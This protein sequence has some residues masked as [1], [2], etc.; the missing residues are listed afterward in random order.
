MILAMFQ[1]LC[2]WEFETIWVNFE[3]PCF[4]TCKHVT[5]EIG[6]SEKCNGLLL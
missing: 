3:K 6:G 4:Y 1:V 2:G 5:G